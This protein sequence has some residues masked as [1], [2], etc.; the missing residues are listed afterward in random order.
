MI[1]GVIE[2]NKGYN[3]LKSSCGSMSKNISNTV[4][5]IEIL[6]EALSKKEGSGTQ[7]D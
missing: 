6:N 3:N 1:K 4:G 5:N 2:N 7:T